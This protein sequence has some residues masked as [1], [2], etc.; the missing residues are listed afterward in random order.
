MHMAH[1]KNN[2]NYNLYYSDTDSIDIDSPLPPEL[3]GSE[4]GQMKL[5]HIF[6]KVIYLAPKV[7]GGVTGNCEVVKV[8]R[9]KNQHL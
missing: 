2:S 3:V 7:Y 6:K 4:P 9:L 5:E 1:F 8:K